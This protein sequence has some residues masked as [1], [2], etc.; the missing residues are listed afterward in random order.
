MGSVPVNE[1]GRPLR[2]AY[3]STSLDV[4]G[5]ERK[6]LSLVERLHPDR[7]QVDIVLLSHAG[8]L[9]DEAAATGA[10]LRVLGWAPRRSRFHHVH[11]MW[12]VA[13]LGPALRS[14]HYDIV[15]TWLFN[16]SAMAAL[17]RP[18]TRIPILIS[19]RER[20]DDY[21]S[22][23]GPVERLLDRWARHSSDAIVAV[24]EAV[25]ADVARH[26]HLD[27]SRI[28]VIRNGAMLPE[29]MP[30]AERA[31]IRAEW[32]YGR[33]EVVVG[34]VANY[35]PHKGLE[36]LLEVVG[37]LRSKHPEMR[38]VLVGEG[39]LR[40]GL[41][42][43]ISELDLGG[44]V[45]LHGTEPDARRL[46]GAFDI[47][48][49]ASESEGGPN[50]VIEA[51]AARIPIVATRAGGTVEAVIEGEGGLLVGVGD[52]KA[53][54]E[55]LSRMVSDPGLRLRMGAAARERAEQVYSVDLY[56]TKT[57]SMYEELAIKKGI[58]R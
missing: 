15:H 35:K 10:R 48:A 18:I 32:G 24:S 14:G 36:L 4:G 8:D 46:Y 23:F 1:L 43:L 49:H 38:L 37:R 28:R 25:R 2:I 20:L 45:R 40:P 56:V 5:A 39:E 9:A 13:R 19:G 42:R 21:K 31:A 30:D 52:A 41:E 29:P 55:A 50:S 34:C 54:A 47:L 44:I 7:F 58:V 33:N 22:S 16:S 27:P 51:S 17:V 6:M 11:W 12:D 3:L 57:T 26:E 53:F